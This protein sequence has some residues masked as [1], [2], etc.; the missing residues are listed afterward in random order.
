MLVTATLRASPAWHI[1]TSSVSFEF[2]N[3]ILTL[4]PTYLLYFSVSQESQGSNP[5]Y[6]RRSDSRRDVRPAD[7]SPQKLSEYTGSAAAF[8]KEEGRQYFLFMCTSSHTCIASL[9]RS[10][11]LCF[12]RSHRPCLVGQGGRIS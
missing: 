4:L 1:S 6:H 2:V 9:S 5:Y 11:S 3:A 7:K 10:V 8:A 12:D